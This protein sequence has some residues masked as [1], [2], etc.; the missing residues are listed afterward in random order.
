MKQISVVHQIEKD[1]AI[2][3]ADFTDDR[4]HEQR[5][6]KEKLEKEEQAIRDGYRKAQENYRQQQTSYEQQSK[7]HKAQR[8]RNRLG[9][10]FSLGFATAGAAALI[11]ISRK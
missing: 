3:I 7:R 2:E 4:L 8:A 1:W 9:F 11:Y 5:Q 10:G 6:K